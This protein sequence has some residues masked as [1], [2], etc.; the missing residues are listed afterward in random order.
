MKVFISWSGEHSQSVAE[1]LRRWIPALI[2]SVTPW[3]SEIDL[4]AGKEWALY[5][6]KALEEADFGIICA[7]NSIYNASSWMIYE[8][9]RLTGKNIAVCPYSIDLEPTR[10]AGS[11][12]AQYQAKR[13]DKT[14]TRELI[15]AINATLKENAISERRLR[16]AFEQQWPR[17][18]RKLKKPFQK[19]TEPK[20]QMLSEDMIK[21]IVGTFDEFAKKKPANLSKKFTLTFSGASWTA[22][23]SDANKNSKIFYYDKASLR[24]IES[25]IRKL[26][27]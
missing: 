4:E 9:A 10:I 16:R 19:Q 25:K 6:H 1:M 17:L 13:A 23:I 26:H 24:W 11:P 20:I 14:G 18:R 27:K 2:P 21:N 5:L 8:F 3:M 12:L 15:F 22:E 7:T